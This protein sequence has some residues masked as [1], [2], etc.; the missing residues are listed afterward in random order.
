LRPSAVKS[1]KEAL[2]WC[3]AQTCKTKSGESSRA[4]QPPCTFTM[5]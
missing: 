3:S 2:C 4:G 5:K 1:I